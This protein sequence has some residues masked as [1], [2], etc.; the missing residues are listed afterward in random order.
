M[1]KNPKMTLKHY[2]FEFFETGFLYVYTWLSWNS[3]CRPGW[4]RTQKIS[5]L[6]L[7][8]TGIKG[9]GHYC[10]TTLKLLNPKNKP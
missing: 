3:L 7:P 5:C 9:M 6:C 4:P 10:L 1:H 8:S 2:F